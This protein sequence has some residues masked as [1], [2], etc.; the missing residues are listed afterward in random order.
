M[1]TY[2][3]FDNFYSFYEQAEFSM[4]LGKQPTKSDYDIYVDTAQD[5]LR[6]NKVTAILG[7]NGSGKTQL[8]KAI[9]FLRWFMVHSAYLADDKSVPFDTFKNHE[10]LPS[11]FEIGFLLKNAQDIYDEYRYELTIENNIVTY[12][13]LYKKTSRLF[14]YI[15]VREY[16]NVKEVMTYK[17]RDFIPPS[18]ADDAPRN[19]SLISY[20]N[21]LDDPTADAIVVMLTQY[22]TNVIEMGRNNKISSSIT[23]V[24][25][26]FNKNKELKKLAEKLLCEFDTGINQINVKKVNFFN[27]DIVNSR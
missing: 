10:Y 18:L 6:L 21:I 15:F 9:A 2:I 7:A 23:Q 17:Y 27:E 26:I 8:L 13:A 5:N 11:N 25:E 16:D 24:A 20:A 19:G 4:L 12:E 3:R 14:S 1:L 22:L